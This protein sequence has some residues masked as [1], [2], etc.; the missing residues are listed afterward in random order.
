MEHD[1]MA[2]QKTDQQKKKG[3]G[4]GFLLYFLLPIVLAAL[5]VVAILEFSGVSVAKVASGIPV[6][7]NLVSE[8][9]AAPA[10]SSADTEKLKKQLKEQQETIDMMK[11]TEDAKNAEIDDLNQQIL[12]LKN[13]LNGA[14]P[15]SDATAQTAGSNSEAEGEEEISPYKEAATSFNKMEDSKA[16]AIISKLDSEK[17]LGVLQQLSGKKRGTILAEMD[18]EAAASYTSTMVDEAEKGG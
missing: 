10:T 5:L 12:K 6:I 15:A 9:T 4:K 18:P 1:S 16:A 14:E 3:K 17:A 8:E 11:E 13:Q 2:K 7:G